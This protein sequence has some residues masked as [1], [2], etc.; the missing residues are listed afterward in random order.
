[1]KGLSKV[2]YEKQ[3]AQVKLEN[4]RISR[5]KEVQALRKERYKK[6]K[7]TKKH[8]E[9]SKLAL[10]IVM[11]LIMLNCIFVEAYAMWLMFVLKDSS[12]LTCLIT[13]AI[14]SSI[15]EVLSYLI[16]SLKATTENT[17]AEGV[18]F[19]LEKNKDVCG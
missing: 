4:E 3:M 1:M 15:G 6:N 11:G 5:L 2:E 17:T 12:A 18:R 8:I 10:F 14:G 7:T 19:Q 13:T 9:T 16:Y